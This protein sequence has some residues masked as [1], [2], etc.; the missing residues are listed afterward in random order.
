MIDKQGLLEILS[1]YQFG[2][3]HK[4]ESQ[5]IFQAIGYK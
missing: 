2:L 3:I 4:A 5:G 1:I